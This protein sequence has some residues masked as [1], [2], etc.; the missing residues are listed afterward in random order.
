MVFE[1]SSVKSKD[2]KQISKILKKEANAEV[3]VR[4]HTALFCAENDVLHHIQLL[5]GKIKELDGLQK[6]LK[7]AATV[8]PSVLCFWYLPKLYS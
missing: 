6:T 4:D 5:K 3:Q 8:S 7:P 1:S 2:V